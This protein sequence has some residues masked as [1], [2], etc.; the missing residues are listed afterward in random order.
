VEHKYRR[1]YLQTSAIVHHRAP[2]QS[3]P[4]PSPS[5][6]QDQFNITLRLPLMLPDWR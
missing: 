5:V 6:Y 2:V 3:F 4:I 1:R